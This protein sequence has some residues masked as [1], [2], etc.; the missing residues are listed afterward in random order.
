[1]RQDLTVLVQSISGFGR[2]QIRKCPSSMQI[3]LYIAQMF[4]LALV[5]I[6]YPLSGKGEIR[7][8][9][10]VTKRYTLES[11]IYKIAISIQ[12]MT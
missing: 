8:Y 9:T 6:Y 10:F 7:R 5:S 1:M 12:S 3:K 4:T 2:D 11:E